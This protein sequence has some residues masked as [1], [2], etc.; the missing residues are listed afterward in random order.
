MRKN[1]FIVFGAFLF[2]GGI[3]L[4][5][6]FLF[7]D[8]FYLVSSIL[9]ILFT[10]SVIGALLDLRINQYLRVAFLVIGLLF[11]IASMIGLLIK[12]ENL[13]LPIY[14]LILAIL[15]IING[16]VESVE[17]YHLFKEKNKMWILIA[18]DSISE[19]VLGVLMVFERHETLRFHSILI[20]ADLF[21]E[22]A[23]KFINEFVEDKRGHIAE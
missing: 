18:I 12:E 13:E 21:F 22:G 17:A 23:I 16:C 10:L 7:K 6:T 1:R 11:L 3:L 5:L 20:A 4:L 9:F 2:G 19:I 14:C 15:E 8:D